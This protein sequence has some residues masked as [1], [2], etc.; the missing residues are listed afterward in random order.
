MIKKAKDIWV[1]GLALFAM[2]FGAGNLIFPPKLGLLLGD[3]WGLGIAGFFTTDVGLSLLAI[4]AAALAGGSFNALAD[5]VHPWFS[6]FLGVVIILTVGPLLALPRTG[7]VTHEMGILPLLPGVSHWI[8]SIVYFGLVIWFVVNPGTVIDKIGKI[9]TPVLLITLISIIIKGISSPMSDIIDTGIDHA[10]GLSFTEG[11]QT[12]DGLAAA[13]FAPII[14]SAL[15]AKGYKSTKSQIKMTIYSGILAMGVIGLVYGGL[16]YIGAQGPSLFSPDIERTE[17]FVGLVG[18]LL[19]PIGIWIM[20]VCV[21]MACFT[22]AVG[23][24]VTAGDYFQDISNGKLPY[25]WNAIITVVISFFIANLGVNSIVKF[26]GPMLTL[27]YPVVI[28]LILMNIFDK[29]IPGNWT[30]RCVVFLAFLVEVP[31][32]LVSYGVNIEGMRDWVNTFPFAE[33]KLEWVM[34][35]LIG[36]V[37][38]IIIDLSLKMNTKKKFQIVSQ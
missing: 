24:A 15:V 17:L 16:I 22:T 21:I 5:K 28:V 31:S 8:T 30:Y 13:I 25:K 10:Y 11:Y 7:A 38:G 27:F 18:Q 32:T 29:L 23:L 37:I 20:S 4:I 14:I 1:V 3:E 35:S 19:G 26:S 9:L 2:M 36:L 34:P 33:N 6:K 12:V